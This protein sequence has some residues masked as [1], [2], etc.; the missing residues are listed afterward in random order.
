M[1]KQIKEIEEAIKYVE[2]ILE[3]FEYTKEA[4]EHSNSILRC[5]KFAKWV[6]S[7]KR[8]IGIDFQRKYKELV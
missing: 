4:I 7:E 1:D 2:S 3:D 6:L 5:L 8:F